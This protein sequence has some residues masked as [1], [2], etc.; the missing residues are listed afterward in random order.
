MEPMAKIGD[1]VAPSTARRAG[2]TMLV[3]G[4]AAGAGALGYARGEVP[5]L[6]LG[7]WSL[8]VVSLPGWGLMR[9]GGG[10]ISSREAVTPSIG[11]SP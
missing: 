8:L 10:S 1:V 5:F 3:G 9:V 7:Y 11:A 4:L 2:S 6:R